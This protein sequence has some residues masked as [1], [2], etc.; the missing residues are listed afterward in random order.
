M[1]GSQREPRLTSRAANHAAEG[2]S[3]WPSLTR[4]NLPLAIAG[5]AGPGWRR[6]PR[7]ETA[8]RR[9]LADISMSCGESPGGQTAVSLRGEELSKGEIRV[10][11]YCRHQTMS[12][13]R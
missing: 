8:H 7:H 2:R 12:G 11:R 13:P 4:L 10:M 9:A 6:W 3:L 5:S 1:A